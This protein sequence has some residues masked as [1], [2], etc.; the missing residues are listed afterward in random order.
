[1]VRLLRND[2]WSDHGG[3]QRRSRPTQ[4]S[5]SCP[6]QISKIDLVTNKV[7]IVYKDEKWA[8][9]QL[10]SVHAT[11][12]GAEKECQRLFKRRGTPLNPYWWEE[13]EVES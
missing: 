6:R 9:N 3:E 12:E 1:V 13:Q 11:E 2:P 10:L 4:K 5:L 8:R 7:Y